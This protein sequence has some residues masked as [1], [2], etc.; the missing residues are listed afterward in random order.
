MLPSACAPHRCDLLSDFG[1]V[2][3]SIP[4]L[5]GREFHY[6]LTQALIDR[7]QVDFHGPSGGVVTSMAFGGLRMT[8][9]ELS[10]TYLS[11]CPHPDIEAGGSKGKRLTEQDKKREM[12]VDESI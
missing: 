6:H 2:T 1:S 12:S 11:E 5:E 4:N 9:E 10:M 8:D 3:P 7:P